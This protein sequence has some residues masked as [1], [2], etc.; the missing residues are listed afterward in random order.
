[1]ISDT[2]TVPP[3]RTIT[4]GTFQ[5]VGQPSGAI[6]HTDPLYWNVFEFAEGHDVIIRDM[7]FIGEN[8]PFD[9]QYVQNQC[10]I[11]WFPHGNQYRDIIIQNCTFRNLFGFALAGTISCESGLI[12][13]NFAQEIG[14]GFNINAPYTS[15]LRNTMIDAEGIEFAGDYGIVDGNEVHGGLVAI[16]VAGRATP[17]AYVP[18]MIVR[19]N[20]VSGCVTGLSVKEMALNTVIE[21]NT[22]ND[23]NNGI[24]VVATFAGTWIENATI[25][26]N[27]IR[28]IV[29][30]AGAGGIGLLVRLD[31]RNT[32]FDANDVQDTV[33]AARIVAETTTLA[34]NI[35]R[36]SS[37]D[38]SVDAIAVDVVLIDNDYATCNGC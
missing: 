12:A 24:I 9:G 23:C 25:R 38:I 16:G 18:D 33:T 10:T 35:L 1:M 29:Q 6:M 3:R 34:N 4:G 21:N 20:T 5:I 32:L 19:N 36:G 8:L 15:Y 22:I 26:N 2:I 37:V 31:A 13:D 27:T 17:G 28:N 14:N 11:L 7:T 30:N